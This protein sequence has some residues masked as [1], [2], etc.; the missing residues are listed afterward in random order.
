MNRRGQ[1]ESC[2]VRTIIKSFI[3][4]KNIIEEILN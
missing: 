3:S 4:F 1:R 2:E